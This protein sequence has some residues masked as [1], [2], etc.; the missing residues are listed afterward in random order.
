ME[1]SGNFMLLLVMGV[2]RAYFGYSG[3]EVYWACW[4]LRLEGSSG[5]VSCWVLL[6][7]HS[8]GCSWD[9]SRHS[10]LHCCGNG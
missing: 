1:I 10:S 7:V 6:E 3:D 2:E 5:P 4:G 8:C 9:P